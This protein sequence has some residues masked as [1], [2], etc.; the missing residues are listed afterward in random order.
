MPTSAGPTRRISAR[1]ST[2]CCPRTS[3]GSGSSPSSWVASPV[4]GAVHNL[5]KEA[6]IR[7]L[8]EPKN[9]LLKQYQKFFQFDDVELIFT[10]DA[11]DGVS[12]EALKRGTGARG[13]RAML[14]EVLLDVMYDLP[15]R[16]DVAKCVIDLDVV[17]SR[18]APTFVTIEDER[19]RR[20]A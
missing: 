14:E 16:S 8:V 15:S 4:I 12:D 5:D 13:L 3:S 1:S 7:I 6:L 10:D 9:A 11:L 20:S 19:G 18:V 17:R 2:G